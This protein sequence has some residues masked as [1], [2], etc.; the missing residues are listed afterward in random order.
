MMLLLE[1]RS[2]PLSEY[3][4]ISRAKFQVIWIGLKICKKQIVAVAIPRRTRILFKQTITSASLRLLLSLSSMWFPRTSLASASRPALP[5]SG[6]PRIR[7][8]G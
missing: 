8:R 7:S 1:T 6:F 5:T 4:Y 2:D 3:R